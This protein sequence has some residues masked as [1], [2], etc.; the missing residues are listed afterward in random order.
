MFCEVTYPFST[1]GRR[2]HREGEQSEFPYADDLVLMSETTQERETNVPNLVASTI[3]EGGQ[4]RFSLLE[5]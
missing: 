4:T 1:C 2:C 5:T 3:C